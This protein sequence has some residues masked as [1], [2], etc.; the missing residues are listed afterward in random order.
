[1]RKPKKGEI[2]FLVEEKRRQ[3]FSHWDCIVTKVGRKYF[4]VKEG[5]ED[6]REIVFCIDTWEEHTEFNSDYRVF[7]NRGEWE[8]HR[9]AEVYVAAFRERF[10]Y[11][12]SGTSLTLS[13]LKE[14]A[15]ILNIE[16]KGIDS[17]LVNLDTG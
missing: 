11:S 14:A 2:L 10:K 9:E 8:D 15:K 3:A 5:I 12:W 7:S 4:Y 16:I 17:G 1:M 6:W 13:Q